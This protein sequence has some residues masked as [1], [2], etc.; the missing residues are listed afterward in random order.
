MSR[1]LLVTVL[2]ASATPTEADADD[3]FVIE[4]ETWG[5]SNGVLHHTD[6]RGL[7]TMYAPEAWLTAEEVTAEE[8]TLEDDAETEPL[9]VLND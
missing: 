2:L 9:P 4:C 3:S 5:V 1:L 8:I 6:E 7:Q